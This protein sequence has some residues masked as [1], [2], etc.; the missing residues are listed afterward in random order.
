MFALALVACL[1]GAPEVETLPGTPK[2][3]GAT[4]LVGAGEDGALGVL[5]QGASLVIWDLETGKRKLAARLPSE[6]WH[7]LSVAPRTGGESERAVVAADGRIVLVH[8]RTGRLISDWKVPRTHV[9]A[10][11]IAWSHDGT[12]VGLIGWEL[13]G[14]IAETG[15]PVLWIEAETGAVVSQLRLPEMSEPIQGLTALSDGRSVAIGTPK[16]VVVL[17]PGVADARTIGI[18]NQGVVGAT[19]DGI[20]VIKRGLLVVIDPS[21]GKTAKELSRVRTPVDLSEQDTGLRMLAG[22]RWAVASS[23]GAV[24]AIDLARGRVITLAAAALGASA[25]VVPSIDGV[26]VL[27]KKVMRLDLGA[28]APESLMLD[29]ICTRGDCKSGDGVLLDLVT[30]RQYSGGFRAGEP[31][32]QGILRYEDGAIYTG[33]FLRGKP[34]GLGRVLSPAGDEKKVKAVNGELKPAP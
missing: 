11:D 24:M 26:T 1:L 10:R 31:S 9:D 13:P 16:R 23:K 4:T 18:E 28:S 27:G 2:P 32:G 20:V 22:G 7:T 33:P 15:M 19:R 25:F 5:V 14:L 17:G 8:L 12:R 6:R 3:L 21:S 34:H 29:K 30:T